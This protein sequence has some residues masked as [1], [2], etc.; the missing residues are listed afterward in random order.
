VHVDV[1]E[2]GGG[3]QPG[4]GNL[5][6]APALAASF[7]GRQFGLKLK[8]RVVRMRVLAP[9]RARSMRSNSAGSACPCYADDAAFAF[10]VCMLR[11]KGA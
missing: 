8:V 3:R 5:T 9:L 11:L 2:S 10:F 4:L 6:R 1:L 7:V